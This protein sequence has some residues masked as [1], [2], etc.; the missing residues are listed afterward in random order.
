M[1]R[2]TGNEK[3]VLLL[4]AIFIAV[5]LNIHRL[6]LLLPEGGA[7]VGTPWSF[8]LPE[9]IFQVVYQGL[10]CYVVGYINLRLLPPPWRLSD[11]WWYL[12]LVN[13][14]LFATFLF[15]GIYSQDQIFDNVTDRRMYRGGYMVRF[16]I[17]GGLILILVKI[18]L[19]YRQQKLKD[20]ENERLKLAY[21]NAEIR[22]L[23]AQVN[24]HF[25]FNALSNLS[26]LVREEPKKAQEYIAHLSRVFRHSLSD[27]QKQLTNLRKE[28]GFLRSHIELLKIRYED[29]LIVSIP[30]SEH[31]D[32]KLPHMSLQ[33]LL[34]NAVKHNFLSPEYPLR[35]DITCTDDTLVFKNTLR[36][37]PFRESSTGIGLLNLN[38]R[39]R[40]L[41]GKEIEIDKTETHF[42]VKLPL[43]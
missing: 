31:W 42:I 16:A 21:A 13:F 35:I 36:K 25:L 11:K 32:K 40:I 15:V 5:S 19:L 26:S 8:N 4:A 23:R 37:Q 27:H 41:T 22:N 14:L 33:P 7:R 20:K 24:P 3:K 34:E 39:Y 38:E 2:L 12:L 10:F 17:S 30:V 9:L 28:M 29:A 1:M 43:I 18:L 6:L